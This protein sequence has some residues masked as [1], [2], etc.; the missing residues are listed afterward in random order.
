MQTR[1]P[2]A[3]LG[4]SPLPRGRPPA[5]ANPPQVSHRL[6][7]CVTRVMQSRP[8]PSTSRQPSPRPAARGLLSPA[9]AARLSTAPAR[10][11]RAAHVSVLGRPGAPRRPHS[12][13]G[14]GGR[15]GAVGWEL[16]LTAL[17]TG[18]GKRDGRT[19]GTKTQL[20]RSPARAGTASRSARPCQTGRTLS[21]GTE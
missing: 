21:G 17:L 18:G 16:C 1:S 6:Q 19:V 4:S 15:A 13:V 9:T 7:R 3:G 10:A 20:G 11:S 5:T 14:T 12:G 2:L 8:L